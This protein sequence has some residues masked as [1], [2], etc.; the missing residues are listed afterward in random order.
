MEETE[1]LF[2]AEQNDKFKRQLDR[3]PNKDP[4][5]NMRV[6]VGE[7]WISGEEEEVGIEATAVSFFYGLVKSV[8]DIIEQDG[9]DKGEVQFFTQPRLVLEKEGN[10]IVVSREINREKETVFQKSGSADI[11]VVAQ[12]AI[13]GAY[14]L[15]SG[16]EDYGNGISETESDSGVTTQL[17]SLTEKLDDSVGRM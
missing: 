14:E 2:R 16:L 3:R 13:D 1:V 12:A 17:Q 11:Q 6:K 10:E 15:I 7:T 5:C 9:I 8:T 4:V